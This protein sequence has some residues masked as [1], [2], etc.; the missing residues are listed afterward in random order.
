MQVWLVMDYYESN[1]LYAVASTKR[2]AIQW[3][4]KREGV[5]DGDIQVDS[6]GDVRVFN[7]M[8]TKFLNY[9]ICAVDVVTEI[10]TPHTSNTQRGI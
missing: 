5:S 6:M 1:R 2:A 8:Y 9:I 3:I 7:P 4:A 10:D